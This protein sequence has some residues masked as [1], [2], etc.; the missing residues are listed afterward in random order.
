VNAV[1][2]IVENN[3]VLKTVE[4][5]VLKNLNFLKNVQKNILKN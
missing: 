1:A 2:T 3:P 5:I 4:I